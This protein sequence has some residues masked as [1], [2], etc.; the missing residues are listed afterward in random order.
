MN[1][2]DSAIEKMLHPENFESEENDK[3]FCADQS[4]VTRGLISVRCDIC[5]GF[6]EEAMFDED[7]GQ[8]EL[9]SL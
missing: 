9:L 3:C 7:Y 6:V 8:M 4:N 1:N 5:G 2:Y